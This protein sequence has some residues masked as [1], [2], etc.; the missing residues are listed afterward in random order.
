MRMLFGGLAVLLGT[1]SVLLAGRYGYKGADTLIDAIISAV[2]FGAIALCAFLFDAA[3]VRLWFMR[4]YAGSIVVGLIA[5]AA[6][7][8]TFTNSLGAIA[9]RGDVTLAQRTKA[10]ETRADDRAELKRLHASLSAL[11]KYAP[12]DAAAVAAAKRAAD[13]ASA[14][15]TVECDKRGPLCKQREIDEAEAATKLAITTSAKAT[16]DRAAKIEADIAAVRARLGEAPAVQN[17]NPLGAALE[18][19]LGI[20][21]SVLTAWQQ[22]IVA[23]VFELCLVGTMVIFELLGHGRQAPLATGAV[24]EVKALSVAAAAPPPAAKKPTKRDS[25]NDFVR[26]SFFPADGEQRTEMK[27]LVNTYRAWCAQ[28]GLAPVAL[29]EFLERIERLCRKLGVDI[30]VGDDQRVYLLNVKLE[31][32]S[33]SATAH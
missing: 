32:G 9:A 13:T 15:R 16:S 4:H 30:E 29:E 27:S 20:G 2:V 26:E 14:N 11:G 17:A 22:A 8:V 12:T 23:G 19:I 5:A 18:A 21:G 28:K 25:V 7:V 6:L 3:A 24:V 1:I 31:A 33:A 10:T